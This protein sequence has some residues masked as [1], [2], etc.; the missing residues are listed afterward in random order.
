MTGGVI[1]DEDRLTEAELRG[2]ALSLG[3]WHIPTIEEDAQ[4]VAPLALLIGEDAQDVQGRHPA[5]IGW[6]IVSV[7]QREESMCRLKI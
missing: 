1:V 4:R 6:V 7:H 3:L 5:I 2:D